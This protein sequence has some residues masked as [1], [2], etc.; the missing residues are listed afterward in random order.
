MST[1][2]E[3]TKPVRR[4][5]KPKAEVQRHALEAF[6]PDEWMATDYVSRNLYGIPDA[7]ILDTA[8]ELMHNVI[9]AGPTGS[10]KT[11]L[12]YAF[13][14]GFVGEKK[15]RKVDGVMTD[16]NFVDPTKRRPL[17]Y[18]PCN[19]AVTPDQLFGSWVPSD[20]GSFN[21]VPGEVLLGV[22]LGAGI[23][24]DEI[25]FLATKIAA[26]LHGLLDKRRTIIY[27][28]AR[29]AGLCHDC[30]FVNGSSAYK[31]QL[32]ATD[33]LF[34]CTRCGA[35]NHT[36]TVFVA[37]KD[38]FFIAAYNPGYRGT[39][40]LN[41]AFLNRF[42]IKINFP[43]DRDIEQ[44]MVYSERL[45]DMAFQLRASYE[46]GDIEVPVSTSML[47]EFEAFALNP[48]LGFSF[49]VENFLNAFG[50]GERQAVSNVMQVNAAQIMADL[51]DEEP[52]EDADE[53][54]IDTDDDEADA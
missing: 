27:K 21:F 53:E 18:I 40:P 50:P 13:A 2:T 54:Y 8:A 43:Y 23:Y 41:E 11:S 9:I 36:D 10:A 19:G 42:A 29:G 32:K 35:E 4:V 5:R 26:V 47:L 30:A 52:D 51:T 28:D 34:T 46:A 38:T 31:P 33:P 3:E 7:A 20:S 15:R 22:I 37:H 6:I 49:A 39:N 45:I 14:A 16:V 25:N 24:G 44:E 12:V 17:I 48:K 1:T